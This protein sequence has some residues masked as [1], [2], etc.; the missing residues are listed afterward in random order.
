MSYEEKGA[1]AAGGILVGLIIGV[2]VGFLLAPK[3]GKETRKDLKNKLADST[4]K[5]KKAINK[6]SEQVIDNIKRIS[7]AGLDDLKALQANLA[8]LNDDINNLISKQ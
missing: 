6:E 3:S 1:S 7:D 5:A 4:D 2:S 8:K